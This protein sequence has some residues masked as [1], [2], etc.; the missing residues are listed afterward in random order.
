MRFQKLQGRAHGW[1]SDRERVIVLK[2]GMSELQTIKT[3]AHE[4]AH[5][6]MHNEREMDPSLTRPRMEVEAESVAY[7]ICRHFGLDTGDYSFAY[8]AS[9]SGGA[10]LQELKASMERIHTASAVII[11][12]MELIMDPEPE[13]ELLFQG[14]REEELI[15]SVSP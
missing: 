14:G 8:L 3:L 4:V 15:M 7:I 5:A 1:Y 10:E 6:I 12:R 11:T 2:E 13:K 9:Y